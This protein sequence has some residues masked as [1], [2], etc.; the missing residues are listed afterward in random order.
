MPHF[1]LISRRNFLRLRASR[2]ALVATG[3]APDHEEIEITLLMRGADRVGAECAD[4]ERDEF[5]RD[6]AGDAR[7]V[8]FAQHAQPSL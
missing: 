8:V 1:L 2:V 3:K 7:D 4:G 5:P 6:A